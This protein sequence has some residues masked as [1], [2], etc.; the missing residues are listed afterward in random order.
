MV[1]WK[2]DILHIRPTAAADLSVI[3]EEVPM[4]LMKCHN[5]AIRVCGSWVPQQEVVDFFR[6]FKR[7]E[8]VTF[9][10]IEDADYQTYSC[11]HTP[12]EA[13]HYED[14]DLKQVD[15]RKV[16]LMQM[17]EEDPKNTVKEVKLKEFRDPNT[18]ISTPQLSYFQPKPKRR[19]RRIA[20]T[21][22]F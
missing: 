10:H 16:N 8:S 20:R 9:F 14:L 1:N 2:E 21:Y 19:R 22:Y 12:L 3:L 7:L 18:I 5:L 13:S 4:I 17:I 6:Q 15:P 11:G